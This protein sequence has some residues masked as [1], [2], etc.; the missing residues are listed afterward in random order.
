MNNNQTCFMR[1]TI[2]KCARRAFGLGHFVPRSRSVI[3]MT[4]LLL[5]AANLFA[6]S[7]GV[8]VQ[9][10]G[11]GNPNINPK[12]RGYADGITLSQ[13]LF[14]GPCGIA[15]D[16]SGQ[17][18]FVA[19]KT[20]NAIRYL[21]LVAGYTWTFDVTYTNL[22]NRPI[23]VAV[24]PYD[25]VY[26]LNRGNINNG[27][28]VTF[29][30][31][32][33][34]VITNAVQLTNATGMT[35]DSFGNIYVTVKSNKLIRI[36][37]YSTNQ[38]VVA[39][40]FPAGTSLQGIA[41]KHNGLVAACDS[42]RNGIYLIDP[43][44]GFVTT[45]A[46]FHGAGD[47]TTNGNNV[48]S[49]N[50]AKFYQPMNVVEAGDGSLLV[51]DYGNNRVKRVLP[52]GVVTNFYGVSSKYWGGS[53]PGWYDT[54]VQVPDSIA[55][56]VQARSPVG[57]AL[58]LDGTVYTTED[59]YHIIRHVTGGSLVPPLTPTA[60]PSG[61]Y[62]TAGYGQVVLKWVAAS[63]ATNYN[64]KRSLTSGGPY[65]NDIIGSTTT[66][67]YSDTSVV[68]GTTYYYV[69][70]DISAGGESANSSEASATPLFSPAPTIFLP[71]TTNYGLVAFSWSMS[72]GATSYNVKRA[73]STN[74]P[75]TTIANTTTNGYSDTSVHQWS[76]VLLC[77]YRPEP[78]RR[79]CGFFAT[80]G[81]HGASA[82]SARSAN[83]IC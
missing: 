83:R 9:T 47:F 81:G 44:T 27:S 80:R 76:D 66:T 25:F 77:G 48:A 8:I 19:D 37:A 58:A 74:G 28:I 62:T 69:V 65:T 38:T 59:F 16:S 29:D 32:G 13:A 42:G 55:P 63:G 33:D 39:T 60:P 24:D 35:L 22:I 34:A 21:D 43:S 71:V 68:D 2:L 30:N 54:T 82:A 41:V 7:T 23:A 61:L 46:G 53:F 6:I 75:F 79:G 20:N 45:N 14:N 1:T 11:G 50:T 73:Q 40:N 26:V 72:A 57:V 18:L 51:T 70:S 56:N 31:W 12:Y 49:S 17:F 15:L 10:L 52:S 36:A 78:R 64:I 67:S 3:V 5:A 4:A